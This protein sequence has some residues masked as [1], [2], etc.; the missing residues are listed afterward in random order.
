M[1]K[2]AVQRMLVATKKKQINCL[3]TWMRNTKTKNRIY[4]NEA[5]IRDIKKK[6][7]NKLLSTTA[8]GVID[9]IKK[10]KALPDKT[11]KGK[12]KIWSKFEKGLM[13]YRNNTMKRTYKAIK[14]EF[15]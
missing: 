15:D 7:L 1:K 4:A 3:K 10:M 11:K 14:N 9:A 2:T 8:G 13:D 6:F 12:F 5:N